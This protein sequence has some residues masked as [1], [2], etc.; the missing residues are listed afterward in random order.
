MES[1]GDRLVQCPLDAIET[2]NGTP[3][4]GGA[5]REARR[6]NRALSRLPELGCS[7]A[8]I[9]D[10]VGKGYTLF[11]GETAEELRQAILRGDTVALANAY[12]IGEFMNYVHFWLRA[13]VARGG[14]AW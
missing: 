8:H 3:F 7:D 6:F 9:L 1:L 10:A 13:S 5:N 2:V 11:P 14:P 12:T 4:L